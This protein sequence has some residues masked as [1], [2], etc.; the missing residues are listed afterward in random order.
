[1]VTRKQL[2]GVSVT[3]VTLILIFAV[4][5]SE[6]ANAD[7]NK[8]KVVR[9]DISYYADHFAGEKTASGEPYDPDDMTAAHK[10]LP[11]GSKVKVVNPDNDRSV[12]LEINDR[13]PYVS[14][15]DLDVSKKAAKKLGMIKDGEIEARMKVIDKPQ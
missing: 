13:G 10:D 6:D 4:I 5:F 15:R 7:K 2:V 3:M 14:G 8:S 11:L 12:V 9:S 1:M